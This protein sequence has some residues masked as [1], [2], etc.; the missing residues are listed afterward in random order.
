MSAPMK[1]LLKQSPRT[2]AI[3]NEY[4]ALLVM[5]SN[6]KG[7]LEQRT[8]CIVTFNKKSEV[9]LEGF[10]HV[11]DC[12]GCLGLIN[13]GTDVF[14]C[15]ITAHARTARPMPGRAVWRIHAVD[16]HCLT[17]SAW[18]FLDA[19]PTMEIHH[20]GQSPVD[21][22]VHP[23]GGIRKLLNNG[24]FYYS[25]DFDLTAVLQNSGDTKSF[26]L[27][28]DA[29]FMWN[30]FMM[31]ELIVFRSRLA[32][33]EQQ[34]MD[35]GGFLTC[36]IRGFASTQPIR[37]DNLNG[38]LSVISRQ[39][40]RRA[41]TR[42]NVRG[43][44]DEGNVANFVET[45]TILWLENRLQFGYVQIRGSVPVFWEQDGNFLG[46]KPNLTRSFEATQPAFNKHLRQITE[47]FG[48]V[49]IVDLLADKTGERDLS[50]AFSKH[51]EQS[52]D[53]QVRYMH[54]DFHKE[55]GNGQGYGAASRILDR[56]QEV[57]MEVGFFSH[58]PTTCE[59]E[60]EQI[61]VFRT[62]CLDCLDRTN[63]IQQIISRDVLDLFLDYNNL[64]PNEDLWQKLSTLWADNGDQLSQIYTGT[65]ALKSSYTRSGRMNL[66]GAL[67]DVTKSVSRLYVNNF[68]DKSRQTTIELLLGLAEGQMGITISDPVN[69][70]V[71]AELARRSV[72]YSSDYKIQV[73][74]GT[75][76]VNGK[77]PTQADL[78]SWLFPRE[79]AQF[80][81]LYMLGFQ[82]LVE[83]SAGQIL[84]AD[85][86]R[87]VFWEDM[88][89]Q[90]LNRREN[91]VLLRSGQLVGTASM[92]FV[93]RSEMHRVRNVEGAFKKTAF[94]GMTGNKGGVGIS[95][96]YA[97]T[98]ICFLNSHLAAG[99]NNVE[100]RHSDY[101]VLASGVRFNRGRQM[102][103]HDTVFWLGDLNYRI[104]LPNDTVRTMLD[105]GDLQHALA[106]MVERDQLASQMI[107]GET[108]PYF[109]EGK[110][111][112]LPT[113]KYDP[114]TDD[115]DT[116]EKARVPAWTDRILTR[117]KNVR[118]LAY[119]S[120][121]KIKFS[122]HRPVYA[123]FEVTVTIIDETKKD[124]LFHEL[125]HE[126]REQMGPDTT[127][128]IND[129]E[130]REAVVT[131][132]RLPH[133][134]TDSKKWWAGEGLASKIPVLPP[135]PG[136]VLNP[137]KLNPFSTKSS[138]QPD[139]VDLASDISSIQNVVPRKPVPDSTESLV[140]SLSRKPVPDSSESLVES[141]SRKPVPDSTES[142]VESLS[143]K[144]VPNGQEN[145]NDSGVVRKPVPL[146]P[147]DSAAGSDNDSYKSL[148]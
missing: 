104:D 114:G 133:P 73:F 1:V 100:E 79:M 46:G 113:Y 143:R 144:P 61:G 29:S 38:L 20:P 53:P 96:M 119:N 43:I 87:R 31:E 148:I 44:D 77:V 92:L 142:L 3:V 127:L 126:R 91:Y 108:F 12:F 76:N 109:N 105:Q 6:P 11:V 135:R 116:S 2:L 134:S 66:A 97:N 19:M 75:F 88:V 58:N 102:K 117:G 68:V 137:E 118:N 70:Y 9:D 51:I 141:L 120:A 56:I 33:D 145:I 37:L 17:K 47:R 130:F 115:Y 85:S 82:E 140:E 8:K 101:K 54:F 110:I 103:D 121:T 62:N 7:S 129:E 14:L 139:F 69:D 84:N 32:A 147:L 30:M 50:V 125:Y 49:Q 24:S 60:T 65:N 23:C 99:M 16:F 52:K 128:L 95:F 40:C 18:D 63:F 4:H 111:T 67:S 28:L 55:V 90:S 71:Q 146:N 138:D 26:S 15:T 74:C 122:D 132:S 13:V 72:E 124:T 34:F 35:A 48:S 83:L 57:I 89:H 78:T 80:P 45:E 131:P 81:D 107:R 123:L 41:G 136:M 86:G 21:V 25:N 59:T 36:V 39:S 94:G 112:F 93:K 5:S 10:K 27:P 22:N 42:F 64:Y 106:R 98:S